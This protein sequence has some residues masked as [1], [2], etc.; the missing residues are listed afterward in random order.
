MRKLVRG[1]HT[2]VANEEHA[3][4]LLGVSSE[5]SGDEKLR[6]IAEKLCDDYGITRV[7]LTLRQSHSSDDNTVS[8]V[9]YDSTTDTFAVSNCYKV[10]IVDRIGGGDALSAGLIHCT[11]A[12][13]SLKETIEFAS[14]ANALKHSVHGDAALFTEAEVEALTCQNDGTI[15]MIR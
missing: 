15:R 3:E 14:A 11:L 4:L 5:K 8:A 6:E 13:K 1:I 10:H 2:L 9:I 7:V 12:K